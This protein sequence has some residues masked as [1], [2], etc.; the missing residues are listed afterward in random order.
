MTDTPTVTLT[1]TA[2]FESVLRL[3]PADSEQEPPRGATIE[4]VAAASGI[5]PDYAPLGQETQFAAGI[6]RIYFFVRFDN[7]ANG[8]AW[9]RVLFREGVPIQ[10]QSYRWAMGESG[11][12]Y[13]FFGD[14]NGYLPGRYE[15]RIFIGAE[16]ASRISFTVGEL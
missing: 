1:A 11:E 14:A 5:T 2:T 6:Q 3:T 8:L 13:F 15:V 12:S 9:T 4:L 7:M 16:E 10:G